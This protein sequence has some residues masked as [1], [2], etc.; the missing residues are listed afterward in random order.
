MIHG[1][2][3]Y[4]KRCDG[5]HVTTRGVEVDIESLVLDYGKIPFDDPA[6]E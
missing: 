2:V 5:Q 1:E 4:D 6:F 3:V